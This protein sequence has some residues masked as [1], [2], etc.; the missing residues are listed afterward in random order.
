MSDPATRRL[1]V[2][3]GRILGAEPR[4]RFLPREII[5]RAATA[6]EGKHERAS[7]RIVPRPPY[8]WSADE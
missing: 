1:R 5:T 3:L 7:V 8:D 4:P 2:A 6:E